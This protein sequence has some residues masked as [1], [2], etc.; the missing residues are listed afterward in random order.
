MKSG[1]A[2]SWAISFA[3]LCMLLLGFFVILHV[4]SGRETQ[5]VQGIQQALGGRPV[6]AAETHDLDP[7]RLF[8][9]GEALLRPEAQA[10]LTAIGSHALRT[11][12]HVRVESIGVDRATRRFDGWELA[13]AR[14]AAIARAIQAGGLPEKAIALSIPEMDGASASTGQRIAIEVIAPR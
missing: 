7:A 8:E 4:Q 6:A 12:Q 1:S 13:A 11:G 2:P 5:V 9:P 3:D 14:A 10:E